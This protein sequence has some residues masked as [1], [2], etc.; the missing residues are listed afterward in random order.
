M[1][2]HAAGFL[3]RGWNFQVATS[4]DRDQ[5]QKGTLPL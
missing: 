5:L 2:M 1:P 4:P 3:V